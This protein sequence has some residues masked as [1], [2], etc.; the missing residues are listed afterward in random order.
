[1]KKTLILFIHL[2]VIC[3]AAQAQLK[4]GFEVQE[5]LELLRV[6]RQQTDTVIKNDKVPSPQQYHMIYRS[7]VGPLQNR[8]DLWVNNNKTAVISIRGTTTSQV[9]WIENFYSAMVPASG[10][11]HINDTTTFKY[12]LATNSRATVHIGWLLGMADLAKTIIPQINRLHQTQGISN[13]IIMGHSQGAAI[14][15]LLRSHLA[16]LQ[17]QKT[18]PLNIVF[19]TYC[20]APPKPGNT[21]Y[22]YDFDYLTRGGWALSVINA[23]DWVPETPF[24]IQTMEDFNKLNPFVNINKATKKQ[25][26]FVRLYIKHIYN[27]L[28]KPS[29]RAVKNNQKYLGHM[30]YKFVKKSLPQFRE[31]AYE[32]NNLFV[33][34][35]TTV[36]LM[37]DN[38][39]QKLFPDKPDNVFTHHMFWPYYYLAQQEY[40]H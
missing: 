37:P 15:Y 39:Y 34:C 30:V 21:Y 11:L 18:I 16:T 1:M 38:A 26:F 6:S 33:H 3:I 7:P 36:M 22:A 8:W 17:Q 5:Y 29:E 12:N 24:S 35:G 4:P 32:P 2:L 40:A 31:P 20:S 28:K 23:A 25:S 19:K 9:S 27:R 13:F 14:A 10:Q